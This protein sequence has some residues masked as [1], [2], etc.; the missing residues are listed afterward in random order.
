M[1]S[2]CRHPAYLCQVRELQQNLVRSQSVRAKLVQTH[3]HLVK[4][5]AKSYINKGISFQ[6]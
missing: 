6:V 5:I 1:P 3:M 4:G 2:P